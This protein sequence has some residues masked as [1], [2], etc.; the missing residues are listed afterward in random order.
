MSIE[1]L[2]GRIETAAMEVVD[3]E[4]ALRTARAAGGMSLGRARINL[5]NANRRFMVALR[6]YGDAV[7]EDVRRGAE[8]VR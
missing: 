8:D 2:S 3:A 4:R 7:I 1:E 6:R 5:R